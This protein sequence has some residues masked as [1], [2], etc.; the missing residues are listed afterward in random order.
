MNGLMDRKTD[1]QTG[2]V[3]RDRERDRDAQRQKEIERER[4]RASTSFW[5][6]SEFA[7]PSMHHKKSALLKVS[8]L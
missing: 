8:Y 3:D 4:L 1:R 7:P 2:T 6:I 5:S